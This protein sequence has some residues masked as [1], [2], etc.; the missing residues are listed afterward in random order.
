MRRLK[1]KELWAY[2]N[3]DCVCEPTS[4]YYRHKP[5]AWIL[6][7]RCNRCRRK[8]KA[9]IPYQ[10]WIR[11]NQCFL[12]IKSISNLC[13]CM[14]SEN[15][16][17]VKQQ[18]LLEWT[19]LKKGV[20]E[21][22]SWSCIWWFYWPTHLG[23]YRSGYMHRWGLPFFSWFLLYRELFFRYMCPGF[24]Q[25]GTGIEANSAASTCNWVECPSNGTWAKVRRT[26][27]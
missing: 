19:M 6:L 17:T 10:K 9:S 24:I 23:G 14:K 5:E 8:N 16:K 20:Q 21:N 1:K 12:K 11:N 25:K 4:V 27:K 13:Q 7:T 15:R 2:R 18:S 3:E 26:S 22:S